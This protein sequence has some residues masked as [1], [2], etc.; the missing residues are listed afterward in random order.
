MDVKVQRGI[1]IIP[2][3]EKMVVVELKKA[4]NLDRSFVLFGGSIYGSD[5]YR[6][7]SNNWDAR[8]FLLDEKH[9][10]IKRAYDPSYEAEVAWQVVEVIPDVK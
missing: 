10:E 3:E 5:Y 4:V 2:K 6:N 1:A 8:L 9:I 7:Y